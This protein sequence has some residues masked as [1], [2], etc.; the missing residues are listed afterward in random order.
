MIIYF[1][2]N[3]DSAIVSCV[4]RTSLLEIKFL[5]LL[6]E[7]AFND[8]WIFLTPT[9]ETSVFEETPILVFFSYYINYL[10]AKALLLIN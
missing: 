3:D 10:T 4:G 7:I 1:S 6:I 9:R 2:P 5:Y 8:N